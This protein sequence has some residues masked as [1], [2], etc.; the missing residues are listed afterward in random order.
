MHDQDNVLGEVV[1]DEDEDG[2]GD[3]ST[4]IA[5]AGDIT[6]TAGQEENMRR[7]LKEAGLYF[8]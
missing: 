5:V 4:F 6:S 8:R 2:D 7:G 1:S 3:G